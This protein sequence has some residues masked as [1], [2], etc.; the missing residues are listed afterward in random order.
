MLVIIN[1]PDGTFQPPVVAQ[2]D[3]SIE[4]P[5]AKRMRCSNVV[6]HD[7]TCATNSVGV[8]ATLVRVKTR[9]RDVVE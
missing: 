3:S 9:I 1:H 8:R 5:I 6:L 7:C 4:A 2:Q